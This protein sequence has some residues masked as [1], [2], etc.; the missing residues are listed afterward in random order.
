MEDRLYY[1]AEKGD[2]LAVKEMLKDH[3][4]LNVNWL[5]PRNGLTA[6]HISASGGHDA[7]VSLLLAHADS[8]V[9]KKSAGGGTPFMFAC[10]SGATL[11]VRL[12]LKDPRVNINEKDSNR[13]S[14]IRVTAFNAHVDTIRWMIASGRE[15][16]LGQ[17]GNPKTDVV[18]AARDSGIREMVALM[19]KFSDNQTQ[20]TMEI[21]KDLG[22]TG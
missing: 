13:F 3:P 20:T 4:A 1:A 6:L 2:V 9:N 22:I 8:D 16:D 5:D 21:R 14:P 15:F 12:L 19:E 18:G 7:I 11:C 17:P 10:A